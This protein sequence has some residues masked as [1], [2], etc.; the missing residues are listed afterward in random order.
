MAQLANWKNIKEIY[1]HFLRVGGAS[2]TFCK[3]IPMFTY[4]TVGYGCFK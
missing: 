1:F 2:F 4:E 3:D